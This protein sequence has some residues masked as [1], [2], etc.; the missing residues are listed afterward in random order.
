MV[1]DTLELLGVGDMVATVDTADAMLKTTNVRLFS[2]EV[3]D[4][5]RLTLMV[6]GNLAICHV[7]LDVGSTA[8]TRMGRA[9][10]HEGIG[11]PDDDTQ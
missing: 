8:A 2:H 5:G 1:I 6:E 4:P 3:F 9:T 10:S 11:W 7:A